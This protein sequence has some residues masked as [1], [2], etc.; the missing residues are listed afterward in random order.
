VH[1]QLVEPGISFEDRKRADRTFVTMLDS[2]EVPPVLSRVMW[3]AVT[4]ATR[5]GGTRAS[6]VGLALWALI[7]AAGMVLLGWGLATATVWMIVVA[8]VG[9]ALAAVTWA[10]QY[11]PGLI[12][13]YALPFVAV[14]ALTSLVGYWIYWL[15]EKA[16]KVARAQLP[17]NRHQ[18]LP[19]PI[20]YQG[21]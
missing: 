20:S 14:P 11:G 18:P 12:A 7:A 3:A 5:S 6:Q 8:L 13:G 2:L 9:P 17:H 21:R 19:E 1:D 16:V 4:L 15:V 10:D